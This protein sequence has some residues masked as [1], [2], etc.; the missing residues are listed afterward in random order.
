MRFKTLF[1]K[2]GKFGGEFDFDKLKVTNP[3]L[4]KKL[5]KQFDIGRKTVVVQLHNG[6]DRTNEKTLRYY[7]MEYANRFVQYGPNS[8]PISFNALEPFFLYN[9]HNSIIQLHSEEESYG[10]SLV[11][12][13][14]FVTEKNFDLNK[15]DFYDNIPENIIYHFSFTAGFD[16]MNFSNNGKTFI[17][18]G[19]SL[20]RQGNE[21]S[22]LMQAGE[23]YDKSDADEYFKDHT[24][25]S[26]EQS[27]TPF[28][29]S[30]G[31]R[32]EENEEPKVVN[33][34]GDA[35]LW[36][37]NVAMLFDV[38]NKSID[39]RL[40]AR[41]ENV[42]FTLFT[43]DFYAMFDSQEKLTKEEFKDYYENQLRSLSA[44]DAV[45]DFSKYCLALPYYVFE[46]EARIVDVTYETQLSS[47]IKSPASKRDFSTVPSQY[48]VFAKPL[49]Y[50]ESEQQAVVKNAELTDESFKVEK[51]GYWRRL[52]VNED[53]FDKS[54]TKII[55]KTW[56]ERSDIF[57][58]S[59]K[60]V[61]KVQQ[62]E[63]FN[64][65]NAGYVYIMR[66]PIHEHN[67]FKIGLTRRDSEKRSKELSN[68]SSADKFFIINSYNTKDCFEAEKQIHK[69]LECYRLTSRREFFRCDLK[70]IMDTCER[71]IEN[72]NR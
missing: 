35:E 28:K 44:Y 46:K 39:L 49:Y 53:G 22:I 45:F 54:G 47:I 32:L 29:K 58:S 63:I 20:V 17:I 16:E 72:I 52:D 36:A 34:K 5:K 69:E 30:L 42:N 6:L 68:T 66:Q 14:D 64:N 12:F 70:I 4:W 10:V 2:T 15:I 21:A 50:L 48:K 8:F 37:H 41:D 59:P 24:R 51:S 60:G 38:K 61:T 3:T 31:L 9:H 71:V 40:V 1:S 13:L 62:V 56:V 18:S 23:S 65:E 19:I 67:I 11:D 25:S 57:Y 26:V 27:L 7:L 55:G 43:D 33:F